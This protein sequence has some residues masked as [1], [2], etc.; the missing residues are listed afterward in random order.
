MLVQ[1]LFCD[2]SGRGETDDAAGCVIVGETVS[3][4]SL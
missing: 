2:E 1:D 4:T 3:G